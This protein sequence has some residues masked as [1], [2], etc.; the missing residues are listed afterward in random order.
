MT[1]AQDVETPENASYTADDIVHLEGLDAVRKRPGMYIGSTDSKGRTH[2]VFEIADNS[3]DEAL[4]G[5]CTEITVTLHADGSVQVDDNGRGIPVDVNSKSGL[6]AVELVMTKL[7]A[8]GKF[9]S[10]GYKSAGGLHGV[11]ASVVNALSQRTDVTVRRDGKVHEISFCR[12]TAGTFASNDPAAKFTRGGGLRVTGKYTGGGTGTSVRFWPDPAIFLPGSSIDADAVIARCRQTAFLVPGLA[13]TAVDSRGADPVI[14]RFQFVGGLVDMVEHLTPAGTKLVTDPVLVTGK[15]DFKETVPMLDEQGHMDNVEVPRDVDVSVAF[16]W[17][18]GYD[19]VVESFV[20]VVRTPLGGTH[21]KGFERAVLTAVRKGIENTRGLLKANEAAPI[22]DDILEGLVAVV[23]VNVPEPQFGGQTKESLA[24]A[25]VTKCV[26]SILEPAM[27]EWITSAKSKAQARVVME[28]VVNASRVRLTQRAQKDAARRK[29]A[30]ETSSMPAKLADCRSTD[31]GR[32]E[33]FIVEGD[34]AA[35]S[36][37]EGRS[38]EYQAILPIRGKILNVE[39]A[40]L[41]QMLDNAECASIIQVVG[42]GTGRTFD[43]DA[44]RYGRI[45]LMADADVDGSHIRTLLATLFMRQM[46]PVIEA[47]RLYAAVPPLFRVK[48]KGRN[49]ESLL[50]YTK[51]D[52][53]RILADLTRK[54]REW[55]TPIA[56][57]KGLGEMN[58]LDLWNTTM[59]PSVRTVRR[60][61]MRDAQ[62]AERTLSLLMGTEVPPRREWIVS[63]AD[64]IDRDAID[65]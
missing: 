16:A 26:T 60:I 55:E 40:T 9:G 48:T 45:M 14:Q 28:K 2:L 3:V 59:D 63:Y 57:F 17:N 21:Q 31:V 62:H 52:L 30:L 4:A 34:S 58:S 64:R 5:H 35:G 24:T 61:T 53:D 47:G 42:A 18:T 27:R 39:K 1:V 65:A 49:P 13:M 44:M 11:G 37:T 38:A 12:G 20:N 8:G 22:L 15:A 32:S 56:R 29:T 43:L 10:S 51:A 25:G 33:L 19:P 46:R 23:S 36:A 50:A 41:K 7:H 6:S 54:G